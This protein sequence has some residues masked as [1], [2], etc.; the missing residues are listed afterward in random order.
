MKKYILIV[1]ALAFTIGLLHL[2]FWADQVFAT[3]GGK[4][5]GWA[6]ACSANK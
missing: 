6:G 4:T 1:L 2:G 5:G 3:A